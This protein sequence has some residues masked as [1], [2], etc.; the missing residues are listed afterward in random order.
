MKLCPICEQE[1]AG[2]SQCPADG[3]TLIDKFRDDP[4][5]GQILKGMYRIEYP[6]SEGAI[7][8]V[9]VAKQM[10]GPPAPL[11]QLELQDGG[12]RRFEPV[13][14]KAMAL[15]PAQRYGQVSE[16]L[17]DLQ[18]HAAEATPAGSGPSIKL[19]RGRGRQSLSIRVRRFDSAEE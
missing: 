1:Y 12:N 11:I 16:L 4:M 2:G 8:Q 5:I 3:A 7:S 19:R 18:H 9:Y 6:L 15:D 14:Q 13:I 10:A 17:K